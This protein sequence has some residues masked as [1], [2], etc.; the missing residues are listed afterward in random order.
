MGRTTSGVKSTKSESDSL[1]R[2]LIATA[3]DGIIVI[4]SHGAVQVYNAACERLFGYSSREVIG[5]NIKILMPEPYH[6]EHDEYLRNFRESGER[7]IIGIGRE[8]VGRR[9]DHS[10]FPMYLSVGESE[11]EG[12]HLFVGIIRDL[13]E[14]KAQAASHEGANRLLAQ[15]VASSDDAIISKT[16]DGII[17]SW[18]RAAEH[19]FGYAATEAIGKSVSILI[20]LDLWPEEERFIE[21]LRA[22]R[23][24]EHYETER[25][26]KDGSVV[27]VSLSVSPICDAKGVVIGAS[28]IARDITEKKRAEARTNMLLSELAHASRLSAMGQMSSAL[29]HE[30]NQPLTAI[31]NYIKATKRTLASITGFPTARANELIENAAHE[32]LRAGAIIKN[33][34]DFVEKR[35]SKR[36]FEN[37]NKV[38]EES[39]RLGFVGVDDVNVNVRLELDPEIPLVLIDKI[40]IQQVMTNLIRNGIEAMQLVDR[41][42]LS[43]STT[44]ADG[45]FVQVTMTDTGPG[46]SPEVLSRLFQPFITTK[47]KGMGIGLTICQ[48]IVEA[49]GGRIWP[50]E[51]RTVGAGF[52]FRLP[53]TEGSDLAA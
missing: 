33:L 28:K 15:L 35:E 31:M 52:S 40:Q 25:L 1:F 2:A 17:T 18:N 49:H 11:L 38:I 19:I 7:R 8:V 24:I 29:A 46:L 30:L 3:V 23:G 13:T 21:Q 27:L 16:L 53:L 12:R 50:I 51:E 26:H 47:E 14:L 32:T 10:T 34:R 42:E 37:L 45:D 5:Q 36:A 44:R 6:G 9:K 20:P 43:I 22:G 4:D 41:R 48:S 39:I